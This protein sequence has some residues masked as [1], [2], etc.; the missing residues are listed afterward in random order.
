MTLSITSRLLTLVALLML[1]ALML[2]SCSTIDD[3]ATDANC[4]KPVVLTASGS[5]A[6][7]TQIGM[8]SADGLY[9]SSTGFDG[10]EQVQLYLRNSAYPTAILSGTYDV[11]TPD[12]EHKSALTFFSGDELL[13]PVEQTNSG[14]PSVTLYGVYPAE[15]TA[16]HTVKYDQTNTSFGAYMYKFSDLMY[17]STGLTWTS[18][19]DKDNAR[20]LQFNHQLSK[21]KLTIVKAP[22]IGAVN[23]VRMV[24]TKRKVS[25]TPAYSGLT[26]GTPETA[27]DDEDGDYILLSEGEE[28]SDAQ[29]TY[30]YCCIFVPD[31]WTDA[32]FIEVEAD[33]GTATFKTAK[34]FTGGK[35]YQLTLNLDPTALNMTA[36]IDD[37]LE[38]DFLGT[39]GESRLHLSAI[40]DYTYTGSPCTPE[41]TV[42]MTT[43]GTTT[44]LVK[45]NDY[46]LVY[47]NNINIGTA[48]V[49]AVGK[50]TYAGEVGLATFK[51][52]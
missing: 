19:A 51:I 52:Q 26:L 8:R 25:V 42:T 38:G 20:N 47:F 32:A 48:T 50:G 45:N 16:S 30:T 39:L 49:V 3:N 2:L 28:A 12:E 11:D 1:A 46:E 7:S 9:E 17:A 44:T 10:G 4:R 35:E 29:Q 31:T 34:T 23:K 40:S 33:G 43:G 22:G 36:T 18:A 37:W 13:Y 21:L 15:S 24:N 27:T 5:D 41:P 6:V 14:S